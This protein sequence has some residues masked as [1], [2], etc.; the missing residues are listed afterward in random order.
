M[1]QERHRD[2]QIS[3]FWGNKRPCVTKFGENE[4]KRWKQH[5]PLD[6][7]PWKNRQWGHAVARNAINSK[8]KPAGLRYLEPRDTVTPVPKRNVGSPKQNITDLHFIKTWLYS[9]RCLRFLWKQ[10]NVRDIA[11]EVVERFKEREASSGYSSSERIYQSDRLF[12]LCYFY[13]T[14]SSLEAIRSH[15]R[16]PITITKTGKIIEI[17]QQPSYRP[18]SGFWNFVQQLVSSRVSFYL[19]CT[20]TCSS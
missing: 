14:V 11:R 17:Y 2:W 8:P 1:R 6:S 4:K 5:A 19:F 3:C 16:V 20:Y 12:Y 7:V 15:A 9:L 13:S 10:K 18:F